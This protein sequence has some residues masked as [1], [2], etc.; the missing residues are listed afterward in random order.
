MKILEKIFYNSL[1]SLENFEFQSHSLAFPNLQLLQSSGGPTIIHSSKWCNQGKQLAPTKTHTYLTW[2]ITGC[3]LIVAKTP[4]ILFKFFPRLRIHQ[5]IINKYYC[6]LIKYGMN[7]LFINTL[8]TPGA[9]INP[10]DITKKSKY[11]YLVLNVI[12]G[13][14]IDPMRLN[15]M[16]TKVCINLELELI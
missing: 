9:F 16:E 7:I 8:K 15:K 6:D 12:F 1:P 5:Y 13:T 2:H 11:Q 4:P 10:S 3:L 14:S